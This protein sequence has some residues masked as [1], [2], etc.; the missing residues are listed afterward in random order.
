[1][2]L[3]Y[4]SDGKLVYQELVECHGLNG[5]LSLVKDES[6]MEHLS[7][8]SEQRKTHMILETNKGQ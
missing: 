2:F 3:V 1:M 5:L 7:L 8:K 4:G 6:L